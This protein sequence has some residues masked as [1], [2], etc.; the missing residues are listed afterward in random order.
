M[1]RI[2][3]AVCIMTAL[4]VFSKEASAIDKGLH[5]KITAHAIA[6][7][8]TRCAQGADGLAPIDT[9]AGDILV[10]FSEREDDPTKIRY[11]NWHFYNANY[12]GKDKKSGVSHFLHRIYKQRIEEF[13]DALKRKKNVMVYEA[14]GRILH[15]IQDMAVPAHVAPNYHVKIKGLRNKP[16]AVDSYLDP[17]QI[18]YSL[19]PERCEILRGETAALVKDHGKTAEGIKSALEAML[20]QLADE[21]RA[22]MKKE[23]P[24]TSPDMQGKTWATVFW[25][26]YDPALKATYPK[27]I[28]DGFAPYAGTDDEKRFNLSNGICKEEG[29]NSV[30]RQFVEGRYRAAVDASIRMIMF[31]ESVSR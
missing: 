31:T 27:H 6:Q 1:T 26:I 20:R 12:D 23:I 29:N 18:D 24:A 9:K 3:L 22:E 2:L 30:C 17:W 16:D 21:T 7:Y 4:T 14:G 15:Y 13:N 5:P 10:N 8:N 25:N 11:A 28:K 19:T